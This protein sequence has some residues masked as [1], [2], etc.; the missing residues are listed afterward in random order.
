MPGQPV[1]G[2]GGFAACAR[3]STTSAAK[4]A[5]KSSSAMI[6]HRAFV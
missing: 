6:P 4:P 1:Y 2:L 5:P 3:K